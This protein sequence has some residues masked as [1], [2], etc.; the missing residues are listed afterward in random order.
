MV[1]CF[2]YLIWWL[3]GRIANGGVGSRERSPKK[4][5]GFGQ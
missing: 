1:A 2:L 5:R 4:P 3:Y